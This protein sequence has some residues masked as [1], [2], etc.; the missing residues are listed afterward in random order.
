MPGYK[1]RPTR[2]REKRLAPLSKSLCHRKGDSVVRTE[3]HHHGRESLPRRVMFLHY[4]HE[5]R[6]TNLKRSR[7]R[8]SARLQ[9]VHL[10]V[11]PR[12][13]PRA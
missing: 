7:Q 10:L 3:G 2:R 5:Y 6:Y 11:A 8:K 9:G 4:M 1:P 13:R 12:P